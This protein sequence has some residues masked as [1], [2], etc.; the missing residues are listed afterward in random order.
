MKMS[1]WFLLLKFG[2]VVGVAMFGSPVMAQGEVS[3]C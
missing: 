1:K 2:I 3:R